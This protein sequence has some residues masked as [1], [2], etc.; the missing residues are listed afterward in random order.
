M[1]D[2][3][4]EDIQ[5]LQAQAKELSQMVSQEGVLAGAELTRL[6]EEMLAVLA[7][8][9]ERCPRLQGQD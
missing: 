2:D 5:R 3:L 6:L 1:P 8:L 7:E 9:A 4:R